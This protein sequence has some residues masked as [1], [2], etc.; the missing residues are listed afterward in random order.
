MK[1]RINAMA[2]ILAM[3][4]ACAAAA[5][6][7]RD[8]GSRNGAA[9]TV[10]SSNDTRRAQTV[11]PNATVF[12]AAEMAAAFA[13]GKNLVNKNG[14]RYLV[15]TGR[16]DSPGD[17][18]VHAHYTDVIYVTDGA[19]TF[20]TGGRLMQ[21][22]T[23]APGELRGKSIQGGVSHQLEKGSLVVVPAGVPHWFKA[24]TSPVVDLVIKV[25]TD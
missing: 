3:F 5:S 13:Q 16:R 12:S 19:A 6:S 15:S 18:E 1:Y 7:G 23:I 9:W 14:M 25:Q 17:V 11:R 21:G 2:V 8:R 22:K 20:I 24:V 4:V 10:R